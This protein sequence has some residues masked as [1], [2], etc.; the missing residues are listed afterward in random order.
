MRS[1]LNSS[2][3]ALSDGPILLLFHKIYCCAVSVEKKEYLTAAHISKVSPGHH[4][5]TNIIDTRHKEVP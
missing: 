5:V 1:T 2:R 3:V 4:T